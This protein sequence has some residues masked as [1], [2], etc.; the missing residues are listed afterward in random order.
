MRPPPIAVRIASSLRRAAAAGHQKIGDVK[1]RNEKQARGSCQQHVKRAA[2]IPHHVL[3]QR[4]AVGGGGNERIIKVLIVDT[5][6][7]DSEVRS[8]LLWRYSGFEPAHRAKIVHIEHLHQLLRRVVVDRRPDLRIGIG[9]LEPRWHHSDNG[10]RLRI[11]IDGA[12]EN[13]RVAAEAALPQTPA[14]YRG[15]T[16]GAAIVRGGK[17]TAQGGLHAKSG[18]EIPRDIGGIQALGQLS[19]GCGKIGARILLKRHAAEGAVLL[20]PFGID[21]AR[22]GVVRGGLAAG[23]SHLLVEH[24]QPVRILEWQRLEQNS[25]HDGEERHVRA[26]AERHN[27]DCY[28]GEPGRAAQ[29]ARTDAQI[30]QELLKRAPAPGGAGLVTQ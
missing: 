10:V 9:E 20:I 13:A 25:A 14:Q 4:T 26:D 23:N 24:Q 16:G 27:E 30:A 17:A 8:C 5:A 21:A 1:A 3:E 12:I 11:E 29:R 22:N 19:A 15:A 7:D 18:K 2:D 28:G 6:A